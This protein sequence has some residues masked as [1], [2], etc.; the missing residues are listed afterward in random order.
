M[1]RRQHFHPR[2]SLPFLFLLLIMLPPAKAIAAFTF[3]VSD[4]Q[5]ETALL[6]YFPL[7]HYTAAA[8][9]HLTEPQVRLKNNAHSLQ[10]TI[11]VIARLPGQ[12][13]HRG[14]LRIHIGLHYKASSGELF[15]ARPKIQTFVMNDISAEHYNAFR[16]SLTDVLAKTLPLVRIHQVKESDL[17][18]TLAKSEMKSM[19]IEEGTVKIVIGF[20]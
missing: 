16:A 17:N 14:Q 6:L 13:R 9:L 8:R 2:R 4:R 15:L 11:P 12:G 7:S 18:H 3:S 5:I 1:R 20:H 19:T 10:L